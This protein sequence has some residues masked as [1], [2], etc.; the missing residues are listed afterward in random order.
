[1]KLIE[2]KHFKVVTGFLDCG[3]VLK[4]EILL[5]QDKNKN[6]NKKSQINKPQATTCIARVQPK[7]QG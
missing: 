2:D 3:P 1:M 4:N 7:S 5:D 6:K